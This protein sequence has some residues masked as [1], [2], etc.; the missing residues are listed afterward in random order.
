MVLYKY[1]PP[2]RKAFLN[3]LLIRFTPPGSFNDPFDSFPA[4]HGFDDTLITAKVNKAGLDIAFNIAL[5]ASLA[6]ANFRA[7]RLARHLAKHGDGVVG[8]RLSPDAG[9]FASVLR[10]A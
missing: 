2:E 4:I 7:T 10:A 6:G 8:E 5:E 9:S 3:E 1:F